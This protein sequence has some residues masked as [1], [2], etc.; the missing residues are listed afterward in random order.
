MNRLLTAIASILL[1]TTD[2][3]AQRF[4]VDG[5][6]YEVTGENT[7]AVISRPASYPPSSWPEYYGDIVIP[8]TA[9]Y[10]DNTYKVT[11]IAD[12]AFASCHKITSVSIPGS[13][14]RIGWSAFSNCYGLTSIDIPDAVET[15][16][17]R[18]FN[19][20]YNLSS[21]QLSRN[22]TFINQQ[23]FY[24]CQNLTSISLPNGLTKLGPNAFK[25]TGLKEI[26]IPK[27][28][29]TI[30]F[31]VFSACDSLRC[32]TVVPENKKYIAE[33]GV[34][35]SKDMS[36]LIQYPAGKPEKTYHFPE[37]TTTIAKEA[38]NTCRNLTA[39]NMPNTITSIGEEAF[40][41]CYNVTHIT[42]PTN[43][44]EI[45]EMAFADCNKLYSITYLAED[46]LYCENIGLRN[47][48]SSATLNYLAKS[49][50]KIAQTAPWNMFQNRIGRDADFVASMSEISADKPAQATGIYDLQGRRV[51]NP[52]K[53]LY[54]VDGRK[55]LIR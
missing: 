46:P 18:A 27:S 10:K 51:N 12:N 4:L 30:F 21:V 14:T 35:F 5:I 19:M 31:G 28:V 13:V 9:T 38:F 24:N 37:I 8:E 33:N 44:T 34:L 55:T 40:Y 1:F 2:I 17:G 25:H 23:A 39:I 26:T 36:E 6:M 11:E 54:I 45:G 42:I 7:C 49:E 53:G 22:L 41:C 50:E 47:D 43:V 16:E 3:E 32:I 52:G 15:I 20:C 29:E 48:K